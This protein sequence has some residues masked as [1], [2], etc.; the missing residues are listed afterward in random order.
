MRRPHK[1]VDR[2]VE[3]LRYNS[4]KLSKFINYVM[5]DGKKSTATKIVYDALDIIKEKEK[6]DPIEVFEEALQNVGPE[7]EVKS[8]RV[9]GANYQVPIPVSQ[10]RQTALAFRWL[11]NFTRA[12]KGKTFAELLANLL[13]ES[14]KGEGPA[15]KKK[16]DTHKMA[17]AN[18]AFAHFAW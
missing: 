17:E 2:I 5:L 12:S 9:G 8:R 6:R 18:K 14:S 10:E 11:I 4:K 1:K 15:V 13:I 7:M 16:E 3:D